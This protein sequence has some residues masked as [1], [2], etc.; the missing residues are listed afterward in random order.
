MSPRRRGDYGVPAPLKNRGDDARLLF[1][2]WIEKDTRA[3]Y[4]SVGELYAFA[5]NFSTLQ[6]GAGFAAGLFGT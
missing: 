3:A 2:N 6:T 5:A 4:F 1:E